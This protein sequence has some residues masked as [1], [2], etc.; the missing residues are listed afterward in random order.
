MIKLATAVLWGSKNLWS[1]IVLFFFFVAVFLS[2]LSFRSLEASLVSLVVIQVSQVLSIPLCDFTSSTNSVFSFSRLFAILTTVWGAPNYNISNIII[3]N[4][5]IIIIYIY[6]IISY[7]GHY[8]HILRPLV[9]SGEC[10]FPHQQ[11]RER[12]LYNC[13][14]A[15]PDGFSV[16]CNCNSCCSAPIPATNCSTDVGPVCYPFL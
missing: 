4:I 9:H 12:S 8:L 1:Y 11:H 3:L 15:I 5:I 7:T 2:Q 10:S 14:V 13:R 16:G 6:I